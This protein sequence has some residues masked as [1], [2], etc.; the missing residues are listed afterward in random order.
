MR[1]LSKIVFINSANIPYS[2]I[3][4]DGNV[5]F[6]GTQG[7][8]KSSILR[9]ILFFYN[10]SPIHLGIPKEKKNFDNF[11]FP[12]SNSFL[13]YEIQRETGAYC[14]AAS[15][16]MGRICFR[17][18]DSTYDKRWFI[19]D[20]HKVIDDWSEIRTRINN[21]SGVNPS[22]MIKTFD[23]FR[24]II[25]GNNR[26][27]DM[28][29]FRKYA[30]LESSKYQNIPRTIQNVFLNTKLD[31]DFIKETIIK[32]MTE[33][34]ASIDL[35]YF[36]GQ[37]REFENEYNDIYLWI[38]TESNGINL[39]TKLAHEVVKKYNAIRYSKKRISELREE[40]N[41]AL[42]KC[43]E[44][45]P[46]IENE[47]RSIKEELDRQNRL[48]NEEDQKFM[49]ERDDL[50]KEINVLEDKIKT[51]RKRKKEYSDMNIA[52][53]I[54]RVSKEEELFL[55]KEKT[56]EIR[57]Q[58][59]AGSNN[60]DLKY[61]HIEE[62]IKTT[63]VARIN[64][65]KSDFAETEKNIAQKERELNLKEKKNN[66][67]IRATFSDKISTIGEK[68]T[69]IR[70]NINREYV[71]RE[72]ILHTIYYGK[73]ISERET[74]ILKL[75]SEIFKYE[76]ERK[77][78]NK[79]IVSLQDEENLLI[80]RCEL[81]H[82][83]IIDR[84]SSEESEAES[85]LN[86]IKGTLD[87]YN[88]SLCEWLSDNVKDWQSNIGKVV[89]KD[90]ILYSKLLSPQL[91]ESSNNIFGIKLDLSGV[92][93]EIATPE[94]LKLHK[95]DE[96]LKIKNFDMQMESQIDARERELKEIKDK[97]NRK[98]K[99]II[100]KVQNL[101]LNIYEAQE[102]IKKCKV[103]ILDYNKR[104]SEKRSLILKNIDK[105]ID[106]LTCQLKSAQ[107]ELEQS[108]NAQA[109]SLKALEREYKDALELLRKEFSEAEDKNKH[110]R[111]EIEEK[112]KKDL[113]LNETARL[114]ELET[115][116]TDINTLNHYESR[117][118][119]ISHELEY[120]KKHR[121]IVS[122][123]EKDKRELFEKENE[124][125][126]AKKDFEQKLTI[127][128]EKYTIRKIKLDN[129][130]KQING[131]LNDKENLLSEN[132]AN[133]KQANAFIS[134]QTLNPLEDRTNFD[135]ATENSCKEIIN[136]LTSRIISQSSDIKSFKMIVN[137]FK[138]G[139]SSRNLFN[140][141]TGLVSDYEF[142][143]FAAGLD[144]FLENNMLQEYQKRI[145]ERYIDIIR[146]IAKETS[147]LTKSSSE[148]NKVINEINADFSK[149]NFVGAIKNI[150]LRQLASENKL[151]QLLLTIKDFNE[152]NQYNM[153]EVD[154]F[155]Q[156]S[157][158]EVNSK[159]VEYLSRFMKALQNEPDT[160]ILGLADSFKLEFRIIENDNDTGW[161]E[162][163]SNVGSDGTDILV[164][165]MINIMLIN[166]F[167]ERVSHKFGDFRI[168]CMMDEIGKLHPNNIKGILKFA[169][170][171]N[172]LLINSSPTTF[173]ADDYKY[174]YLLEKE[175]D[176]R[177]RVISL[178]RH[179]N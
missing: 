35:E 1:N 15:R 140:F 30:I 95:R 104:A 159:A 162:K 5:H 72:K 48:L 92:D 70:E 131:N 89:D 161:I 55:E 154:L 11:Y 63:A 16:S 64:K 122:D 29:E 105:T 67:S 103:E 91:C 130:A 144:C 76:T 83:S 68:I 31:A 87:N 106:D 138:D 123:Y 18:I 142:M 60:I 75:E 19:G 47:I 34:N 21:Y 141:K 126:N 42:K 12:Y 108:K 167:K 44:D 45:K 124:F 32:S 61:R 115:S 116:G 97:Q 146:R 168:H 137:S 86:K 127:L 117:I 80:E 66:D 28:V 157:R 177:T 2:E 107:S 79:E 176:N 46:E 147:D 3:R 57:N 135:R 109:R 90:N 4:L 84:L 33:E 53:I 133:I 178:I 9:A 148:I 20:N 78:L 136:D 158:S 74:L 50:N 56:E 165:A 37:I 71:K 98:E 10:A 96:E 171:R 73:D 17:F 134:D 139:F 41:F 125:N 14:I 111:D 174:T 58:L 40:L 22:K 112:K 143:D 43:I 93:K 27:P 26:R 150:S 25:Y 152:E 101:G 65:L 173:N 121:S 52:E 59:I 149:D 39:K 153:G 129:E 88:G 170:E 36:R 118:K 7:V 145:S 156:D 100:D 6:I 155:S 51:C 81:K 169:N 175:K 69:D 120:I 102:H 23:F 164:K 62:A 128:H 114:S 179:L 166:V 113:A 49:K 99:E 38:K 82:N 172:I 94:L 151:V 77:S 54:I 160:K 119:E 110:S 13:I 85:R 163:I 132:E 24:D 8:G